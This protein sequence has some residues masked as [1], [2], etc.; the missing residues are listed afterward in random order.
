MNP[1]ANMSALLQSFK[2]TQTYFKN[3][4]FSTLSFS[5]NHDNARLPSIISD[6]VLIKNIITWTFAGDGIPT[7]YYGQEASYSGGDDPYNREAL[8]FTSYST[9]VSLYSHAAALNE[10]RRLAFADKSSKYGS[11]AASIAASSNSAIAVSKA[12]M[13]TVLTNAG[14]SSNANWNIPSTGYKAGTQ[15]VDMVSAS[16]NVVTVASDGSIAVTFNAGNPQVY[17]P[18]TIINSTGTCGSKA[19]HTGTSSGAFTITAFNGVIAVVAVAMA[20]FALL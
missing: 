2:D 6:P 5:E 17:L 3:G 9:S 12:P 14:N 11:T 10:A 16:C 20:S 13:L 8:W 18:T 7:W 4:A 19:Q 15:L 1:Q